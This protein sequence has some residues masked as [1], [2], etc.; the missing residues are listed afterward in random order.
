MA[1]TKAINNSNYYYLLTMASQISRF[2]LLFFSARDG[3]KGFVHGKQERYYWGT[4]PVFSFHSDRRSKLPRLASNLWSCCL[5]LQSTWDYRHV[6]TCPAQVSFFL[7]PF[8]FIFMFIQINTKSTVKFQKQSFEILIRNVLI[9]T[10]WTA[11]FK[12]I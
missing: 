10:G 8:L 7:R 12:K 4:C 6:L 3:T 9:N 1:L 11:I 5:C 2:L